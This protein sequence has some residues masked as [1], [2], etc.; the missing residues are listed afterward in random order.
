M[1]KWS[2]FQSSAPGHTGRWV[3]VCEDDG[4]SVV[5][6]SDHTYPN[7]TTCLRDALEHGYIDAPPEEYSPQ[8]ALTL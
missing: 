5:D 8:L 3:W 2:F 6:V 7:Y 4:A 1:L